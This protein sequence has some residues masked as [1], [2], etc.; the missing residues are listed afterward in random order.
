MCGIAGRVG[1]SAGSK[2][3]VTAAIN[4][5]AHR[6][7]DDQGYFTAPGVE[8][9]MAR[10]AIIDVA[11]GQ[12]PKQDSTGKI[13]IVFNGEI[14]NHR[15]VQEIV[16]KSG[17]KLAGDS[18]AEALAELYKIK[19]EYFVNDLRGMFA[20]AI[21]DGRDNS[22]LL[23]RDRIGEK[24][25]LYCETTA[26]NLV[27]ASEMRAIFAF[28]VKSNVDES[29]IA[30]FLR[31]GYL[32]SP[33]TIISGVK[34]LPPAHLLKFK[35]GK[36]N[37]LRYWQLPEFK[38]K[39]IDK[40]AA[41]KLLSEALENAVVS[42][43]S[44]ERPLGTYLSGGI[45]ST[46]VTAFAVR[47]SNIKV[48]TFSIGFDDQA[49]DE[50][51][52]ARNVANFLG[53][54]HHEIVVR[55]DPELILRKIGQ[56]LDQPFGDSSIIPTFLLNEFASKEVIVALGGD[57][58]DESMGGYDRYRAA[59][60]LQKLNPLISAA[61]P[62][63]QAINRFGYA[64][65]NRRG[66]RL[67]EAAKPYGSTRDRYL[68]LVSLIHSDE[69]NPLLHPNIRSKS[70]DLNPLQ[71]NWD[72]LNISDESERARLLD[73]QSYLP[74]DL[75]F[76]TDIS[77]MANSLE[78]RAPFL[79]YRYLEV[80]HSIPTKFKI[81]NGEGKYLLREMARAMVPA[82]LIDRPKMGFAIP[83]A[84]W[85]RGPIKEMA[86]ELLL[87]QRARERGWVDPKTI[88]KYWLMHQSG[89]DYDRI[90]WPALML[91]L[92]ARNWVDQGK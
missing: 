8:L 60:A 89:R 65:L 24:P 59:P 38:E 84:L 15:E 7:P 14:Y 45:D 18:E 11:H 68:D 57:G 42:Q 1:S 9:G 51:T 26:G 41:T 78:L 74:S 40:A 37:L 5:L 79:D 17:G 91:E 30:N 34:T 90:L 67:L 70:A 44:S 61:K 92:W 28:G 29:Q 52:H 47:N 19:G 10:L 6:G 22:L 63:T 81:H 71:R 12:Q 48:N 49:F 87:G 3:A 32:N 55:P 72:L 31:L 73:L 86:H 23:A 83:R 69:L 27:F 85:L 77:S 54:D 88:E 80:A 50:S 64:K 4:S 46:L 35:D 39:Q 82:K 13:E 36:A 2:N 75:L 58:G 21:W 62:L 16:R 43:M 25:L 33:E 20:I 56:V 53:T 66:K 76:K